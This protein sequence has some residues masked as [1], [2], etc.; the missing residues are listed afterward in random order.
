M[1]TRSISARDN[2]CGSRFTFDLLF[3]SLLRTFWVGSP[4]R[5]HEKTKEDM[6]MASPSVTANS[7]TL[8]E[9]RSTFATLPTI[10]LPLF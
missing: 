10:S 2:F 8:C 7:V 5:P 6:S 4:M 1:M 9:G 3:N